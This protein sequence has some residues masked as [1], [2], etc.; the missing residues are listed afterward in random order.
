MRISFNFILGV[1]VCCEI[2]HWAWRRGEQ[3]RAD[4]R[5]PEE[6]HITAYHEAGHLCY[7]LSHPEYPTPDSASIALNSGGPGT[8]GVVNTVSKGV[9]RGEKELRF[10]IAMRLAGRAAEEIFAGEVSEGVGTDMAV[11]TEEA[12]QIVKLGLGHKTEIRAIQE[13]YSSEQALVRMEQE[14]SQI[15]TEEYAHAREYLLQ[16]KDVVERTAQALVERDTI[17]GEEALSIFQE[18]PE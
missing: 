7:H 18:Q 9:L 13:G 16:N 14:A 3:V 12:Y 17:T 8:D 11:A 4:P 1:V 15:L 5:T 2:F 10:T 6:R